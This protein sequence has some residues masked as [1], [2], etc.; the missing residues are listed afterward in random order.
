MLSCVFTVQCVKF[1]QAELY[2]LSR[3]HTHTHRTT[4]E[5]IDT[6]QQ[7][8]WESSHTHSTQT[9]KCVFW[10]L[11]MSLKVYFCCFIH[12]HS[13]TP[14]QKVDQLHSPCLQKQV[15]FQQSSLLSWWEYMWSLLCTETHTNV[16]VCLQF[17]LL[18]LPDLNTQNLTIADQMLTI[19]LF[20][21]SMN[22]WRDS[23]CGSQQSNWICSDQLSIYKLDCK[24]N[25]HTH[26]N[27]TKSHNHT[28]Y[29]WIKFK[30][31]SVV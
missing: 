13:Q 17:S 2:T 20:Y 21:R 31:R 26:N 25:Q 5:S 28:A 24:T 19:L 4:D 12:K 23:N 16:Y 18:R 7:T 14:T 3:K 15:E 9:S 30:P 22:C 1:C 8:N 27:C 11:Q 6:T 10:I 29:N